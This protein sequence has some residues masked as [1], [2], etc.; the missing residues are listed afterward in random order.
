MTDEIKTTREVVGA[1]AELIK[2]A[3]ENAQA[4]EAAQNLGQAAVTITRTINTALLPLAAINFAFE[5]AR[6]YFDGEFQRDLLDRTR[7][8]PLESVVDP[9]ASIAGPALQGIAFA[10]D[11]PNLK[12]MYLSL[13]ATSMDKRV[14]ANAHPAF[15]EIIKQLEGE[16]AR[17]LGIVLKNSGALPI[18]RIRAQ[19]T[20]TQGYRP[21]GSHMMDLRNMETMDCIEDPNQPAMV[22]NWLRLG[23]VEVRYDE[24]LMGDKAYAWVEERPEYKRLKNEYEVG[25]TTVSHQPGRIARTAFGL[26]FATAAGVLT[27]QFQIPLTP[28]PTSGG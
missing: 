24:F 11:E 2:A 6:K 8:I 1:V 21:L 23:L 9:K 10:Q 20:H 12:N 19:D 15:V 17:L 27:E 4:R 13:I 18:A 5:R 7:D 16:E 28:S 25:N 26:K 3:G 14:A 22:D